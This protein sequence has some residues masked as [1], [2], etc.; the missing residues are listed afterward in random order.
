MKENRDD[1]R[2]RWWQDHMCGE[3]Y[4]PSMK[5]RKRGHDYC[6]RCIYMIT[7]VVA[8][9]RP[10]L[11]TLRG[12]DAQHPEPWVEPS[13][14]GERVLECWKRIRKF[15]SELRSMDVQ[16]MPDHLHG[17]LFMT[18]YSEWPLGTAITGFKKGC[19]D[20][21]RE[22]GLGLLWEA[23]YQDTILTH[24]GQLDNMK[25][26][27]REN[28]YRLWVKRHE[29]EYFV[30]KHNVTLGGREV[31]V[32]GNRFLLGHPDKA[33]VVCSRSLNEREIEERVDS[34]MRRAFD[35]AVLVSACISPGEKAVMRAAYDH[36]ARM[37]V[38]LE[39][40]FSEFWKPGGRQFDMC[41]TGRL[42]L[43]APWPHH[44][45]RRVI[46]REQCLTLNELARSIVANE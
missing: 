5:R 34:F 18:R 17:I 7:L 36:G 25:N 38:L 13:E 1:R 14:L 30:V 29:P 20:Y 22:M 19:N 35:G 26:Y 12:P 11:G 44:N 21:S 9:R 43:V 4:V 45:E 15:H 24:R 32:A 3:S 23:G 37:I 33:L 39:N 31:A 46:S 27:L 41:A 2:R 42:L 6:K 10:V 28:P 8:G 40:G 16:L